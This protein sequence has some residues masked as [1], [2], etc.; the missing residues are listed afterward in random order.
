MSTNGGGL[1]EPAATAK[2]FVD[3]VV[4]GEHL[5][6]WDLL[7]TAGRDTV[8]A[9]ATA[10]GMA[11]ELADRLRSGTAPVDERDTY[12]ADLVN[13]L[14]AELAG[15]DVDHLVYEDAGEGIVR[16]LTPVPPGLGVP[17]PV[18][19]LELRAVA[20]RWF[21]ERLSAIRPG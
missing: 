11:G 8:L 15:C 4:W 13:G 20:T 6:V 19:V 16:A 17:L 7:S 3:A 2:R 9:T 18:A 14:R 10:R 1:P 21:V 5:F 12:L